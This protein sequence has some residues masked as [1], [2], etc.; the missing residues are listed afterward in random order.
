MDLVDYVLIAKE[1]LMKEIVGL[2]VMSD[3]EPAKKAV[4]SYPGAEILITVDKDQKYGEVFLLCYTE[5]AKEAFMS[6]IREMEAAI[7]AQRIAEQQIEEA[8]KAAEWAR[9]NVV[10]ED[11]PIIPRKW[12]SAFTQDTEHEIN[13]NSY[14][15]SREPIV[16]EI[17]RPKKFFHQKYTFLDRDANFGG[18]QEF[19]A[20]KDPNNIRI[21]Q[22]D[23]GIQAAPFFSEGSAQTTWFRP[24]NK[25]VQCT[26]TGIGVEP[27]TPSGRDDMLASLERAV[28]KIEKAL[29]QNETL[30]ICNETFQVAGDEE[31]LDGAQADN[32]LRELKNFADPTYSKSKILTAI[33]WRPRSQGMVAVSAV[34][35]LSFDQRAIIAGQTSVAYVLLWDFR[36]LVTPTVLMQSPHEILN[37]RFCQTNPHIVAGGTISGQV[38]LWDTSDFMK[39]KKNKKED[40]DASFDD[41]NEVACLPK[42]ISNVDYSH[43]RAV[44]DLF[45]LPPS[46]QF[47]YRGMLVANE[48]LDGKSHQFVTVAGDG[49]V[50]VWD[51]RF[52][53]IA[54]DELRH[55]G[56]AKHV[57][58][59][60]ATNKEGGAFKTLWVPIW[61]AH[62]KRME[63]VG[64]LS[65]CRA[66]YC[67]SP[68][69]GETEFE[70]GNVTSKN[71]RRA[72]VRSH[73]LLTTEEG[74]ILCADISGGKSDAGKEDDKDDD[75]ADSRDHCVWMVPD[76][77]RPCICMQISP[78]FPNII[79]TVGD[80]KF[81]VWKIGED[82]PLFVSP[83]SATHM[84][85]G[86]WSPTRPAVL[87]VACADGSLMAWD[88][89]DSSYRPSIELKA[90]HSRIT[91]VEF[92]SGSA[93]NVRQQLLAVGDESGTL[94]IFEI[95]RN[96]TRPLHKEETIMS[97][98]LDR[99]LLRMK[100]L[101]GVTVSA[102][103]TKEN[104]T[105]FNE[106]NAWNSSAE[107]KNVDSE[108]TK[109]LS[110]EDVAKEEEMF[111]KL[112]AQFIAELGLLSVELPSYAKKMGVDVA[113]PE[114]KGNK[115]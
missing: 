74:D 108:E 100:Y 104:P 75:N 65:I 16:I 70:I 110:Q 101:K 47:N 44:A 23:L 61:R 93:A 9:L 31:M 41:D 114:V 69:A 28:L 60:K 94:H 82:K 86:A 106:V 55:I 30:D 35:N 78:F 72:D 10:F 40:E 8:R 6:N 67:S 62:L 14:K 71:V 50:L 49:Q 15:R 63:G 33:D 113:I 19:R 12:Q 18:T 105:S 112:E 26:S 103:E 83:L 24:A 45:W 68:P 89:T 46:T 27:S 87:I 37:F 43:K 39:K 92:L 111:A 13:I 11:K 109:A 58:L 1:D 2:G 57:P 96:L 84:T 66:A 88:F 81:H 90:T 99:E 36:Y 29:Q 77:S 22:K 53:Q 76:H 54:N 51:T 95:P 97:K 20:Y 48:H 79:L 107:G 52:N 21:R 80:W 38:V 64:E 85:G 91:S 5:D 98:F 3:F 42:Y 73:V 34:E 32:E 102:G 115:K 4:E 25:A 56:R 17:Q 7:E 59:E